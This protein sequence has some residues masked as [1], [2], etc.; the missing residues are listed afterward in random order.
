MHYN[1]TARCGKV[2]TR[3]S[4]FGPPSYHHFS[5][6]CIMTA[7]SKISARS[8]ARQTRYVID[9]HSETMRLLFDARVT[10]VSH[11]RANERPADINSHTYFTTNGPSR[12][13][14]G[15][16]SHYL[17]FFGKIRDNNRDDTRAR[18]CVRRVKIADARLLFS[19]NLYE[20]T[21]RCRRR[22]TETTNACSRL[23]E[24]LLS[25]KSFLGY[26][27]SEENRSR[28][29]VRAHGSWLR[30]PTLQRVRIVRETGGSSIR[31]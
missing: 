22:A 7:R 25:E 21:H 15:T 18:C 11:W 23:G 9:P 8:R 3:T 19:V 5:S 12:E 30:S 1:D 6:E 26:Y 14:I 29:R 24:L 28:A 27:A 17:A 2:V 16:R 13:I 20:R 10:R 31:D 4:S